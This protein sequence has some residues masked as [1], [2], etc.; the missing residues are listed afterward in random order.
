MYLTVT[1][2]SPNVVP[3][4]IE[5]VITAFP[6]PVAVSSPVSSTFTTESLD[7]DQIT[8]QFAASSG[9]TAAA[10]VYFDL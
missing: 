2:H 5:Q 8:F 4:S 6:R 7:V 10:S 1:A 3:S 9:A